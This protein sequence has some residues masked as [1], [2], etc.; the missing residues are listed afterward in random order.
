MKIGILGAGKI[1]GKM[2]QTLNMMNDEK[3][4]LYAV[5]SSSLEKSENF[6]KNYNIKKAY[7]SYEELAK[8]SNI[9]LIYIST[10]HT[11]HFEHAM[12]CLENNR[13]V[14]VEKPFAVNKKQA[15][16]MF[17]K[18]TEKNLFITEAMWTRFMP[19]GK[20]LQSVAAD[21][22]IG[23]A[24]SVQATIG[25][26]ISNVERM[27]NPALAGGALLD[28]G[29]YSLHFAM[30]VFGNDFI[31]CGGECVHLYS[32][33][34][35]AESMT[36]KWDKSIASLHA[37]ML[38]ETGNPGYV[39]GSEGYLKVDNI[40]NPK[41]ITRYDNSGSLVETVDFSKQFTGYE[42]EIIGSC[43]AIESGK[44]ECEEVPHSLTLQVMETM[45]KLRKDWGVKYPCDK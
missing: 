28:V 45:D 16:I 11:M 37:T 6:A 4:E 15:Q 33:V 42:Y 27:I 19:S 38:S 36:M 34:D 25:Y 31:S 35:A 39:F 26:N 9:D 2:A 24:S 1:A 20:Y 32:G 23:D 22:V 14:L 44:T 18:A 30:M 13:N 41:I 12:L 21:K 7:G 8:D 3:Y 43:R 10:I 17:D 29:I 40:N 5:G